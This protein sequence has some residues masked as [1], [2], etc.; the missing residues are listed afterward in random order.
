MTD[1]MPLVLLVLT[2][3]LTCISCGGAVVAVVSSRRPAS[4][5]LSDTV[6]ELV[7]LTEKMMHQQR[8]VKM[9]NV[10]SA[11]RENTFDAG[12]GRDGAAVNSPAAAAAN[13]KIA[14]LNAARVKGL[15]I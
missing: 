10:R 4:L 6:G 8:K 15:R 14:L 2:F 1:N 9:Q 13:S 11:S 3:V 5:E 12:E 7:A